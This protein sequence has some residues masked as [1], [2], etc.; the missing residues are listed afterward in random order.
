M[1]E[2]KIDKVPFKKANYLL[3]V[4]GIACIVA[5]YVCISLDKAP[6]GFGALGLTIGPILLVIGYLIGFLA[7]MYRKK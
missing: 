4:S 1:R 7:I 3:L 5:G 6:Y 2:R